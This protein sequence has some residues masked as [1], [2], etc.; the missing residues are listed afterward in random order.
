MLDSLERCPICGS[1]ALARFGSRPY[2]VCAACRSKERTRTLYLML[3]T[4]DLLGGG[5]SVLHIAPEPALVP[6]LRAAYGEAYTI[7][8]IHADALGAF[9]PRID[10]EIVDLTNL[11]ASPWRRFDLVLHSHAMAGLRASWQLVFLRLQALLNPGGWQIFAAPLGCD[12]SRE[13]LGD[14]PAAER[15]KRYGQFDHYRRIGRHDFLADMNNIAVLSGSEHVMDA[16]EA[17]GDADMRR[18]AG[19]PNV[20]AM[21][22]RP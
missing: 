9:D 14:M 12:W 16:R 2:G 7:C 15:R 8:D 18:I 1:H 10:R 4:L 5:R 13:D 20:F 17:L 19:D 3:R 11:P 22:K 21:R 6:A